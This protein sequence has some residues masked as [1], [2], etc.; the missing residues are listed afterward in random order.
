M[1]FYGAFP[2]RPRSS[3]LTRVMMVVILASA[4]C[5]L[6]LVDSRE[7]IA[8]TSLEAEASQPGSPAIKF[9]SECLVLPPTERFGRAALHRDAVAAQ[10]VAGRFSP[11]RAGDVLT[12]GDGSTRKWEALKASKDGSFS[13]RALGGG[14]AYFSVTADKE[15]IM[16]LEAAGH[17]AVHV[18]GEPRGGDPY[19]YGYLHLPVVLR[20]GSNDFLFQVGRGKLSAKLVPPKA[21][22]ALDLSDP[23]LPD[24]LVGQEV[25]TWAAVVVVNA[26]KDRLDELEMQAS[27]AGAPPAVSKLASIPP[28][29]IRKVG[30]RLQAPAPQKE[31]NCEVQLKLTHGP[32]DKQSLL[33]AALFT[34]GVRRPEQTHK[35]TFVSSLDGSVQYY[36]LVPRTHGQEATS[37]GSKK[38]GLVLTLHGAA[39]EATGQAACFTPKPWAHVV[40][41]TNRRPYGFDWEDWGRLDALEVLDVV[42]HE[43]GTDPQRTYLT[44]HSMGGHGTWHLG[45]TYPDRFAAIGPSA[46]W[47]SMWSYAGARRPEHPDALQ[48]MVLRAVSPSDT[49]ALARNYALEGIYVL[50]GDKDDNVPVQQARTMIKHLADFHR[51]FAYY[52]RPGAGHWWGNPCVDWP[53]MFEFFTRHTLPARAAVRQ[54]QF[55]TASPGVSSHCHWASIEAQIHALQISSI[56]LRYDPGKR[57]FAGTTSNVARLALDLG[58]VSPGGTIQVELDGQKLPAIDKPANGTRPRLRRRHDQWS[59]LDRPDPSHKSPERYGPFKDAFRNHALFV[60]GTRGTPEQNAWSFARARYDA[61]TFYYRG[62]GSVDVIADEAFAANAE[63]DRAVILYGNAQSN[64]AWQVLLAKS[65]VQVVNGRVRIGDRE[66][67][68]EDLACLF[69]QP[70]MGSDRALV[71]VVSGTGLPGMRLTEYLPYFISGVGY[72]D[73]ILLGCETLRTGAAGVRAAGFFGEDWGVDSGEFAWRK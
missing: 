64:R 37:Q 6:C 8:R 50:H 27:C 68:G 48:E 5:V 63:P 4:A 2:R 49:L 40:A 32:A 15:Q 9:P 22:V 3:A 26:S 7:T 35:R 47:I 24:L 30:F 13:H 1:L 11:P 16:L 52:E 55:T 57:S 38:P 54:V 70:R 25:E 60:Y 19:S 46:G 39:V 62:N 12:L 36:S 65:P 45:V 61:E 34:I 42:E 41:P 14:Y 23:T 10:L 72:P 66:V 18:N 69:I 20:Q 43:L 17:S 29:S 73:C 51:D 67:T 31:G 71:G 59:L 33:D 53:P 58:H 28:L 21:P 56:D 44:G